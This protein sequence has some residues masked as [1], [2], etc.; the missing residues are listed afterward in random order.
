MPPASFACICCGFTSFTEKPLLKESETLRI[1]SS[2]GT[3]ET[4]PVPH[5]EKLEEQY[6]SAYYGENNVKFISP[7]EKMVEGATLRRTWWIHSLISPEGKVLD[8]GCGRGLLLKYLNKLKH[9]AFGVERSELAAT[10]ALQT[11]GITIYTKP[12]VECN[13]GTNTFDAI[14][15]WHVLEHIEHPS[16]TLEKIYKLLNPSIAGSRFFRVS[17]GFILILKDIIIIFPKKDLSNCLP[18]KGLLLLI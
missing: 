17:F 11:E 15:I 14:I 1:C 6:S 8:I 3:G 16:E 4:F 12:F 2:C 18:V 10:R 9:P 5:P 13:F 7:L